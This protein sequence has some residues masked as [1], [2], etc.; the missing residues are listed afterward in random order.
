MEASN[1]LDDSAKEFLND[2][3][4]AVRVHWGRGGADLDGRWDSGD[5][6]A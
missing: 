6:F 3:E 5:A 1:V 2:R 4:R